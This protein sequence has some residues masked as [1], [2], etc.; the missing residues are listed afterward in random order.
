M[1]GRSVNDT[2]LWDT[3]TGDLVGVYE[4]I[5]HAIFAPDGRRI[6]TWSNESQLQV[7]P[8]L[9]P[10]EELV[11]RASKIVNRLRPLSR[12]DR[13]QTYIDTTGCDAILANTDRE[14]ALDVDA[15]NTLGFAAQIT[16]RALGVLRHNGSMK[17]ELMVNEGPNVASF[18]SMDFGGE[19]K[20]V[21]FNRLTRRIAYRM[22]N[23]VLR[24]FGMAVPLDYAMWIEAS[25]RI[26]MVQTDEQTGDAISVEY[27]PLLVY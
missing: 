17:I 9:T 26:L 7:W 24:D 19:L 2:R 1:F 6:V 8:A 12:I 13:C 25:D 15:R 4:R 18:H 21:E 20:R 10:I 16:N 22:Q 14:L 11:K 3:Q 5:G 27:F 23:G